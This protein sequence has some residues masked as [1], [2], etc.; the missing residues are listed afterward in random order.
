[1]AKMTYAYTPTSVGGITKTLNEVFASMQDGQQ[2][3]NRSANTNVMVAVSSREILGEMEPTIDALALVHPSR[4][5][6]VY[7]DDSL[8]DLTVELSARCH[9]LSKSQHVCSEVVRIGAPREK[10]WLVPSLVRGQ[11]LTG[12]PTELLL[13]DA[14][15]SRELLDRLAPLADV[16]FLDSEELAP[17]KDMLAEAARLSSNIVDVQW[18]ALAPWRDEIKSAFSKPAV[19]ELAPCITAVA[20]KAIGGTRETPPF[21]ALLLG[22]WI[23][24]R[25]GLTQVMGPHGGLRA[26]YPAGG[27]REIGIQFESAPGATAAVAEVAFA[28]RT[29]EGRVGSVRFAARNGIETIV[30]VGRPFRSSRPV[31]EEDRAALLRRYFLIGESTTNYNASLREALHLRQIE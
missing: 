25:L 2:E 12:T 23:V 19:R 10:L 22:G 7:V 3:F 13:Y 24:Q 26:R 16:V 14:G 1:M 20:I 28:V 17:Q 30:D 15:V 31:E 5:F 11:F 4:F 27:N 9:G 29:P 21:G 6:V 18:I 8:S